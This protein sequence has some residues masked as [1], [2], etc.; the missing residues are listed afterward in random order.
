MFQSNGQI[1]H[2]LFNPK[3]EE[4]F[5]RVY[6]EK[7]KMEILWMMSEMRQLFMGLK[8][9]DVPEIT[10]VTKLAGTKNRVTNTQLGRIAM[11]LMSLNP[12]PASR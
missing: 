8:W 10:S 5:R 12:V 4:P 11:Q 2:F 3:S 9:K 1:Y 7:Y 6:R